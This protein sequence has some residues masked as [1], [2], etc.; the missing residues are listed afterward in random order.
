MPF[1]SFSNADIQFTKNREEK[2]YIMVNTLPIKKQVELIGQRKF[3]AMGLDEGKKAFVLY[4]I[5]PS[6]EIQDTMHLFLTAEIALL[7]ID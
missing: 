4:I 3:H 1:L 6:L 7:S 5:S 2:S